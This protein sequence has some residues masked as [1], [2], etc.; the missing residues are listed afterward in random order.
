M[1]G[2]DGGG[3]IGQ[4]IYKRTCRRPRPDCFIFANQAQR[5]HRDLMSNATLLNVSDD[6]GSTTDKP[7]SKPAGGSPRRALRKRKAPAG[8]DRRDDTSLDDTLDQVLVE[9]AD[10]NMRRSTNNGRR[11]KDNNNNNNVASDD[12]GRESDT[13]AGRRNQSR[14]RN[15][16]GGSG[17]SADADIDTDS[18]DGYSEDDA[19]STP[20][21]KRARHDTAQSP[22]LSRASARSTET[23]HQMHHLMRLVNSVST[24]GVHSASNTGAAEG[25]NAAAS[26]VLSAVSDT[27]SLTDEEANRRLITAAA[28]FARGAR[29][30]ADAAYMGGSGGVGSNTGTSGG[31]G[32]GA[33][34]SND[35]E[36][37][38][39]D[40][41]LLFDFTLVIMQ[42]AVL[43]NMLD[44]VCPLLEKILPLMVVSGPDFNGVRICG[45]NESK[46]CYVRSQFTCDGAFV[47]PNAI[48]VHGGIERHMRTAGGSEGVERCVRF[49]VPTKIMRANVASTP[50]GMNMR[51]FKS[52][53]S[54]E[55]VCGACDPGSIRAR[56]VGGMITMHPDVSNLRPE[57]EAQINNPE[58][59]DPDLALD[60]EATF[61]LDIEM[62][63]NTLNMAALYE[64]Q[65]VS[66]SV[67]EP[68][69][70]ILDERPDP[71]YKHM[72]MTV[73]VSGD[74]GSHVSEFYATCRW[75][76]L[77]QGD[78][79]VS[80]PATPNRSAGGGSDE[81][82]N[83]FMA[84]P[85][86]RSTYTVSGVD[87][88]CS[89]S[90][91]MLN[92]LQTRFT[93]MYK[94]KEMG[95][96]LAKVRGRISVG[97]KRNQPIAIEHDSTQY[98]VLMLQ[99]PADPNPTPPE[100]EKAGAAAAAADP[101]TTE[102]N[103]N[104]RT[105]RA[106]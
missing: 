5:Q 11:N 53:Q 106:G 64:A 43:R 30:R 38:P 65:D 68:A 7:T 86:P 70:Q 102:G 44:S 79:T 9:V 26:A 17:A 84:Q 59:W 51:I 15:A 54:E 96:F 10:K 91:E 66:F 14:A 77:A 32:T 36:Q 40:I 28:A 63:R 56:S 25:S 89:M 19:G 48:Q 92:S 41:N 58:M 42:P 61:T 85:T 31:S 27:S 81:D 78:G 24:T 80:Q 1:G 60:H 39:N 98:R 99:S 20:R 105:R 2:D 103:S 16:T 93:N 88:K 73:R 3:D 69:L 8:G 50:A 62:L 23:I 71:V 72:V 75:D 82:G 18:G 33:S 74:K 87:D 67:R 104:R 76:E 45:Y 34:A 57:E 22:S 55:I 47:S 100:Q 13:E 49:H 35:S 12:D 95:L 46:I 97:L 37:T 52:G 101:A 21:S 6:T 29:D 83:G 94:A 4:D 90:D